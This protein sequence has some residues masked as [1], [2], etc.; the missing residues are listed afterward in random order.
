MMG[1]AIQDAVWAL[2]AS[3]RPYNQTIHGTIKLVKREQRSLHTGCTHR[4]IDGG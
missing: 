3:I 1:Q 2:S 4:Q